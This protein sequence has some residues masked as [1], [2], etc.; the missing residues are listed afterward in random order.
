MRFLLVPK[1]ESATIKGTFAG[2]ILLDAVGFVPNKPFP[3]SLT[4]EGKIEVS[5]AREKALCT[6]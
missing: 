2:I 3:L 5:R 1:R 4:S 6:V